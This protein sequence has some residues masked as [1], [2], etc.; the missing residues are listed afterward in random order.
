MRSNSVSKQAQ[1]SFPKFRTSPR[2]VRFSLGQSGPSLPASSTDE[3]NGKS[4]STNGAQ[5]A[6]FAGAATAFAIPNANITA[7]SQF[8][9]VQIGVTGVAQVSNLLYRR[10]SSLQTVRNFERPFRFPSLPIGNRRYSR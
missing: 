1:Q 5:V 9:T 2:G 6:G 7:P 10:A 3:K 4:G 8:S